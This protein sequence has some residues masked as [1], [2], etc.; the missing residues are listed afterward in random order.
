MSSMLISFLRCLVLCKDFLY[1]FPFVAVPALAE[2]LHSA[3]NGVF[4]FVP[5]CVVNA[6]KITQDIK[7]LLLTLKSWKKFFK[8]R[9]L[10]SPLWDSRGTSDSR[11]EE[12][13]DEVIS[14]DLLPLNDSHITTLLHRSSGSRSSTTFSE[15]PSLLPFS[16]AGK[17][18]RT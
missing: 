10:P 11:G 6:W 5:I 8:N 9:P 15:L 18:F 3:E 2:K 12:V 16:A 7:K 1:I 14:S 17:C 4:Y 13:F